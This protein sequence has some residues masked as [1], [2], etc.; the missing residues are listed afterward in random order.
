MQAISAR[1][2]SEDLQWLI[3]LN[4]PGASTPSDKVRALLQQ[5]RKQ[6]EGTA[7]YGAALAWMRELVAPAMAGIGAYEHR[8]GVH[9]ELVRLMGE[10]A[11]QCMALLLASQLRE[12]QKQAAALTLEDQLAQRAFHL[13]STLL[14]IAMPPDTDVYDP[15]HLSKH[16]PAVLELA[17]RIAQERKEKND[18]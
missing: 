4:I 17:G 8:A 11:P 13:V 9:S 16:I 3:A 1:V 2:S 10:A 14:R 6:Q 12:G 5:V 7:D 15:K 18:D